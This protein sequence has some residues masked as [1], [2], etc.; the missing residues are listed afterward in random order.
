MGSRDLRSWRRTA[1]R[2]ALRRGPG[3]RTTLHPKV[4]FPWEMG[5]RC[6][7]GENL[8]EGSGAGGH[9]STRRGDVA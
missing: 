1:A 2:R 9:G 8:P 7:E 5:L 6:P 4:L 3:E